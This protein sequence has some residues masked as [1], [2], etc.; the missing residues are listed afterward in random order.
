[1]NVTIIR[2]SDEHKLLWSALDVVVSQVVANRPIKTPLLGEG[3][4]GSNLDTVKPSHSV[5]G[6][7]NRWDVYVKVS[8]FF[9]FSFGPV[10]K[11]PT[12]L[13]MVW[14]SSKTEHRRRVP[15]DSGPI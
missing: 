15:L 6:Y 2:A 1:M 7:I 14:C 11:V 4:V 12:L 9:F 3:S 8:F 10:S 13:I 5:P